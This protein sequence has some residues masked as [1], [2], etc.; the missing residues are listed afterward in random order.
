MAK[1]LDEYEVPVAIKTLY[2]S[3][4]KR[5]DA[6]GPEEDALLARVTEAKS[7]GS[8]LTAENY[9]DQLKLLNQIEDEHMAKE[10]GENVVVAPTLI[11]IRKNYCDSEEGGY[12][13]TISV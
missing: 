2:A 4:F 5:T 13:C 8:Q 10:F 1:Q 9:V 3:N 7:R 11:P 6:Y 12:R